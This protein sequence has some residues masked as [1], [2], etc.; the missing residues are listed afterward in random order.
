MRRISKETEEKILELYN[1]KISNVKI[2]KQ[3]GCTD[4]TVGRVLKDNNLESHLKPHAIKMINEDFA[5][6][7]ICE[8]VK[9][10]RS[11]RLIK[12]DVLTSYRNAKCN[13][14]NVA[15][16][17]Y[18]ANED[19]DLYLHYSYKSFKYNNSKKYIFELNEQD[20][21][22]IY[23]K[24]EGKCF[25]TNIDMNCKLLNG[26]KERDYSL[27][28][29][30]IIPSL[31]YIKDNCVMC[32]FKINRI[33]SNLTLQEIKNWMPNWYLKIENKFINENHLD[34]LCK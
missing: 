1:T 4:I 13:S 25:Y 3:V 12:I 22:D 5:E 30:K 33:K 29:D 23:N 6:C 26:W 34:W 27:S 28:I 21:I 8:I 15:S 32:I 11:F 24:Q 10:I 19:I 20:Y 9:P 16:W 31:G 17:K 2:A 7:Y 18:K 14:C